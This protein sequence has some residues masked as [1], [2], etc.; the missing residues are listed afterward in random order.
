M[1]KLPDQAAN[2]KIRL[3]AICLAEFLRGFAHFERPATGGLVWA[4]RRI[5]AKFGAP[6]CLRAQPRGIVRGLWRGPT[7]P[8]RCVP[9]PGSPSSR[10]WAVFEIRHDGII[11]INERHYPADDPIGQRYH[12]VERVVD[13]RDRAMTL[14]IQLGVVPGR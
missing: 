12:A 10:F 14:D 1:V 13:M 8:V 2:E 11:D 3:R 6:R 7:L 9:S 5:L 4:A